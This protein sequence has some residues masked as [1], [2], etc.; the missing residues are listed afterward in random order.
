M[1]QTALRESLEMSDRGNPKQTIGNAVRVLT[2]DPVF[3]GAIRLNELSDRIDIVRKMNWKRD[4]VALCDTDKYYII[5]HM[6]KYYGISYENVIDKAI[7]I[8]ANENRYHPVIEI[9]EGLK[10]DGIPRVENALTHFLGAEKTEFTTESLKVFML[11]AVAR[12]YEPG[13]KFETSICLVGDQGAGKSTF[14]RLLAIKDEYFSD[15]LKKLDDE[16]V[17]RKLQGHWI[18]EMPEMLATL[19]ARTVEDIKSFL[20]RQKETYKTPYHKHPKDRRRRCVFAGTSN[21]LEVLPM[22]RSGNRRIIPI[23]THADRAEV[24]ILDNE[25]ESRAYIMQMWAEIMEIYRSGN[26]SLTIPR[27]LAEKL[28]EYQA[29][30]TP[31][32]SDG[33]L[34][35]QFLKDT[36][37]RFV[38]VSMLAYE[39]LHYSEY[40][41]VKNNERHRIAETMRTMKG[42][43]PAGMQRFARYGSQRA[44]KRVGASREND[45]TPVP[46]QMLLPFTE[47]S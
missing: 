6:E 16:N 14:F 35:E 42:W 18:I 21:K 33:E 27:H 12:L 44:W 19:N 17:F 4:D 13:I 1:P 43:E 7:E 20:S 38:C 32:D 2:E 15:D 46:E 24:H 34:I 29:R 5:M 22:D 26:Y 41:R 39:A 25:K 30:F 3:A 28:A 11:G 31:E 10:W 23:E 37:E 47:N 9:L 36:E 40:D 8:V 45:F